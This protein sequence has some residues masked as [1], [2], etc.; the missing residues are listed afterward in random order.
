MGEK[1]RIFPDSRRPRGP[2]PHRASASARLL[3]F[4][5]PAEKPPGSRVFFAGSRAWLVVATVGATLTG[6]AT[7]G[8]RF[9]RWQPANSSALTAELPPAL[10]AS[11]DVLFAE[12]RQPGQPRPSRRNDPATDFRLGRNLFDLHLA[13]EAGASR[14]AAT[15]AAAIAARLPGPD[16]EFY[17]R[18]ST[19][20]A[21]MTPNVD[22]TRALLPATGSVEWKVTRTLPVEV[23][24]GRWSEAARIAAAT[25]STAFFAE[26]DTLAMLRWLNDQKE[27]AFA[28]GTLRAI[29]ALMGRLEQGP[30][31][32][33]DLVPLG[34][35]L[36][37]L[38]RRDGDLG[39]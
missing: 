9:L 37:Q 6:L 17:R 25:G 21:V 13:L 8:P 4:P 31:D 7:L 32:P 27:V 3:R 33:G 18:L 34:S 10:T 14:D 24:F 5:T 36:Q 1:E 30:L 28:A 12:L 29:W 38:V 16:G 22:A 19:Q 35:E 20:L 26:R 23:C 15:A 39:S 11:P 2:E